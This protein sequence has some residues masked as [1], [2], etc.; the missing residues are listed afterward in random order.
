MGFRVSFAPRRSCPLWVK[1]RHEGL[2]P[3]CLI[4]TQKQTL[5]GDSWM[6]AKRHYEP[7]ALQ[8]SRQL[9]QLDDERLF[10]CAQILDGTFVF[11]SAL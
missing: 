11:C 2:K 1:S 5:P 8:Q 3:R 10:S 4:L 9:S 7:Y 6:S